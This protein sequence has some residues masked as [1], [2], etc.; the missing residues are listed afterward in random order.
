MEY[1]L[2]EMLSVNQLPLLHDLLI[3]QF[4]NWQLGFCL[5]IPSDNSVII[6]KQ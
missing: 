1:P 3:G 2:Q 6:V 5:Q 4:D